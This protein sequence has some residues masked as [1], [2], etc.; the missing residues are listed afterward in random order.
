MGDCIHCGHPAGWLKSRHKECDDRYKATRQQLVQRVSAGIRQNEPFEAI[1]AAVKPL[2]REGFVRGEELSEVMLEAWAD[3]MDRF[4]ADQL[5]ST[6]EEARLMGF[7]QNSG[8]EQRLRGLPAF[9]K[10]AQA[11]VLRDLSNGVIQSRVQFTG[12]MPNLQRGETLVW[13]FP[14]TE[15]LE[16]R[17]RREYVG[18]SQGVSF[19]VMKGVTYRVGGSKGHAVERQERVSLGTGTL[20]VTDKHLYFAGDQHSFRVPYAKIVSFNQY[21]NGLGI[22]RDAATAKPQLFLVSDGWFLCNMI[23]LLASA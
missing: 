3:A 18:T 12:S 21:S 15:Y 17:I 1:T 11:A 14:G 8:L 9:R 22:M 13:V 5:I 2:A 6:D 16:D 7:V 19:R 20:F 4:F 10:L 23:G